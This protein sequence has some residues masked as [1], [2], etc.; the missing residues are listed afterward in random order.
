[1]RHRDQSRDDGGEPDRSGERPPGPVTW[2]GSRPP[3]PSTATSTTR[4][5]RCPQR[6]ARRRSRQPR[7]RRRRPGQHPQLG[8]RNG[9][10]AVERSSAPERKPESGGRGRDRPRSGDTRP[11]P[12]RHPRIAARRR[13]EL[14]GDARCGAAPHP[15]RSNIRASS[16]SISA[17]SPAPISEL[18][19]A[20][21][22]GG[23][24]LKILALG[25]V[26][27]VGLYRD[28]IAA[29][30]TDYLVKPPGREQLTALF[31]KN[32]GGGGTAAGSAR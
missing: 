26:N 15:R 25:T 18:S 27:D 12:R 8:V 9:C 2:R 19:A 24:D 10:A 11:H 7:A 21:A 14:R 23:A 30:A 6:V 3:P 1:M 29:G 32:T 4:S 13:A 28:M 22:V 5:H 16:S 17:K 31:E 20:R